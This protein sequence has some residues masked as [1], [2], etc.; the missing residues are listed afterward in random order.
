MSYYT[1]RYYYENLP[2]RGLSIIE[3][4]LQICHSGHSSG[5]LVY[6]DYSAHFILEGKG[7][8]TVGDKAYE[9]NSGVGFMIMPDIPT[10]Y[11]ADEHEPWKYIYAT[12]KGADA[13][14]MVS[15]CGLN[16]SNMIFTFPNDAETVSLI[17]KMHSVGKDNNANGYDTLGYFQIIM[18][19]LIREHNKSTPRQLTPNHYI[20]SAISYIDNHLSYN[21]GVNDVA[22]YIGIDRTHLYRLF[23]EQLGISPSKYI[24][25]ERLKRAISLMEHKQLSINEIAISAGFYDLSHFTK[26]FTEGY[27]ITPGKYKKTVLNR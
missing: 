26:A 24:I 1:E 10:L 25:N 4:G 23:T 7:V 16:E 13:K 9:I 12:I 21:I 5:R 17:K 2:D 27:G 20:R 11:V 22:A 14:A 19:N 18:S 6:P 3:C 15:R 8:Y